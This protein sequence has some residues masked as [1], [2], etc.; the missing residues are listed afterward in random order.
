[1]HTFLLIDIY[2]FIELFQFQEI[3]PL[4]RIRIVIIYHFITSPSVLQ[5]LALLNI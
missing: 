5:S 4:L 1:M 3:E 2:V